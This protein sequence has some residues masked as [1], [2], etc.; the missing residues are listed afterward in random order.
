MPLTP[1]NVH[2]ASMSWPAPVIAQMLAAT[3]MGG[4]SII[5]GR[6]DASDLL[7]AIKSERGTSAF[8]PT[9]VL[10]DFIAATRKDPAALESLEAVMHAGSP[11]PTELLAELGDTIGDRYL[12]GWGMTE[13]SGGVAS[14]T[15]RSDFRRRHTFRDFFSTVGRPVPET[16]IQVIDLDG[17]PLPNDGS[18]G[19]LIISSPSVMAG[20]WDDEDASARAIVDGFY[21]T[22]DM[23]SIDPDGYVYLTERRTDL[24]L[25]GGMNVY[26]RE[27]ELTLREIS[28]V[29]DI[30]VVGAPHPRWGQTPVAFVVVEPGANL[31]ETAIV[32]FSR[33]R[34]ASYKKPTKVAFVSELPRTP[35]GKL[36]RVS[37]REQA[38]RLPGSANA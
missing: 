15:T 38:A 5:M 24:I 21:H 20:Y 4:T 17:K 26:P 8:L 1:V 34:L 2:T 16:V 25:S 6:W 18:V 33:D 13:I 32:A 3:Y 23:G 28:G 10:K 30:A 29:L 37:L 19:E 11:A 9:P 36:D 12:E 27:I 35:N 14:A 7:D 22:G 31:T